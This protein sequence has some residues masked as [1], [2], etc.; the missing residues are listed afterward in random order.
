MA[1]IPLRK[2]CVQIFDFLLAGITSYL[3]VC[4]NF[5]LALRVG[6]LVAIRESGIEGD[7]IHIVRGGVKEYSKDAQGK[8][9]C[10]KKIS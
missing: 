1:L 10:N 4:L 7:V 5:N 2:K 9:G 6:E 8:S 3:A